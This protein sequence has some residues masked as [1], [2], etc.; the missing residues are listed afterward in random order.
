[1]LGFW[2]IIVGLIGLLAGICEMLRTNKQRAATA[3]PRVTIDGTSI[4]ISGFSPEAMT[5][6]I[7]TVQT[8][9]TSANGS[10]VAGRTAK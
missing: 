5:K 3:E 4:T 10:A 8:V 9:A 1:M 2:P 6:L 7:E